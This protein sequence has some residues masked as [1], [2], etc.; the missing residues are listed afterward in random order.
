MRKKR[1]E[2]RRTHRKRENAQ[3]R[4][5]RIEAI[6]DAYGSLEAFEEATWK[7]LKAPPPNRHKYRSHDGRRLLL[8]STWE[9]RFCELLDA[10]ELEWDY[11]PSTF[12]INGKNYTPD[13][14][15]Y[16]PLGGCYVELH[17]MGGNWRTHNNEKI[18]TAQRAIPLG[19][20]WPLVVLD[21]TMMPGVF[22]F[23][24]ALLGKAAA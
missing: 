3:D 14:F 6:L 23:R 18:R 20:G 10:L 21:E 13:F 17:V 16:T 9:V 4:A 11:E 15:V 24:D 7:P 1:D 2:F 8:R 19:C 12:L 22:A 5:A